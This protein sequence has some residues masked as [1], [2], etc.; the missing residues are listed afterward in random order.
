M[1]F[2][3]RSTGAASRAAAGL[4]AAGVLLC[5]GCII[6]P[7]N[8]HEYGSRH[9]VSEK[10]AARLQPGVTTKEEVFLQ[11]GEPDHASEDGRRLGYAWSKV[12]ALIF[13]GGGYSG[14]VGEAKKNFLLQVTFDAQ[15]RLAALSVVKQ[16]GEG[17]DAAVVNAAP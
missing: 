13:V 8:Y 14:A 17:I 7:V 12:R 16:W 1:N 3:L 4:L 15:D 10:T 6:I 9:N 11:L 2:R 5:A